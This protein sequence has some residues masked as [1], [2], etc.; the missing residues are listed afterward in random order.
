MK[1]FFN[2]SLIIVCL[3]TCI[4]P[5]CKKEDTDIPNIVVSDPDNDIPTDPDTIIITSLQ[6][7]TAPD[8]VS[9]YAGEVLDLSGLIVTLQKSSG[10]ETDVFLD[11]FGT[12]EILTSI[13][14]GSQITDP[15]T[16]SI[17]HTPSGKYA[18]LEISVVRSFTDNRDDQ[19]YDLISIGD[20]I[21]M[22]DN[23]DHLVD[24]SWYYNND[25]LTHAETYGRLY[26]WESAQNACPTGWHLP[27]HLEWEELYNFLGGESV[28]GEKIKE[29]G[30]TH[31]SSP[32]NA[33][34]ESGFGALPGGTRY[35]QNDF[36]NLGTGG[37]Y[38][39]SSEDSDNSNYGYYVILSNERQ[40][41]T[42]NWY[43]KF[44]GFSV[45]CIKD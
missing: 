20:Q 30:T 3:F 4:M 26:N 36:R 32:N 40:Y 9:Y 7:K 23:L 13:E 38:W 45:R 10:D 11:D 37:R 16:L 14:N 5:G 39:S 19:E 35:S 28:A 22:A 29:A 24:N 8:K 25:S 27:S 31:W 6:V 18:E 41:V 12:N 44:Y 17:V 34:N 33:T 42:P 21:W 15:L 1:S 43:H 2:T